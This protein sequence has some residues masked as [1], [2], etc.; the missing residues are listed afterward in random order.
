MKIA[1]IGTGVVGTT[2]AGK[3][4]ELGHDVAMGTRDRETTL[5]RAESN[6][7]SGRSFSEWFNE[8]QEVDLLNF[9][10]LPKDSDLYI[11]ATSGVASLDVLSLVGKN[12]L[13]GKTILD[14]SNPLDFSKDMPPTLSVCNI[15]SLAER[16]QSE[17][18][19]SHVVKGLN[20]MNAN[21]MINPSRVPGEHNVFL[22]GNSSQAKE[23]VVSLLRE[24]GWTDRMI[25]DLGDI[26]TA[27]GPEMLL[28]IWLR[29][30]GAIG[31]PDFNFHIARV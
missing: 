11:N 5:S 24:M 17:F 28:P 13:K 10:D 25:I 21:V 15:D 7:M 3:L 23:T 18:R 8:H 30:W 27:R 1:V 31:T 16:I 19:E 6:P 9:E 26:T 4:L 22:S 12:K 14:I 20:T 2:I 29:L